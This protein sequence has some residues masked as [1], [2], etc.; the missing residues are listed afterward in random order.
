MRPPPTVVPCPRRQIIVGVVLSVRDA[1][2]WPFCHND[3]IMTTLDRRED[4]YVHGGITK[5]V[6]HEHTHKIV[7][8]H[9]QSLH[10][11]E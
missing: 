9:C 10:A 6:T 3:Y 2:N 11:M 7:S 5:N 4:R 8:E 1:I